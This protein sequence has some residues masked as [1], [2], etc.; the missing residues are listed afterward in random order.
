MHT[1]QKS[2]VGPFPELVTPQG[3]D[4]TVESAKA[5]RRLRPI[6]IIYTPLMLILAIFSF[7]SPH[8]LLEAPFPA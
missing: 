5:R 3:I 8:P 6:T 1:L 4:S 7:R 2:K